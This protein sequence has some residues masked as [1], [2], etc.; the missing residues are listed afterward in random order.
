MDV[1]RLLIENFISSGQ[2][3]ELRTYLANLK[4]GVIVFKQLEKIKSNDE[5]NQQA[6]VSD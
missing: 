6:D 1:S 2:D 5:V 3:K 4:E